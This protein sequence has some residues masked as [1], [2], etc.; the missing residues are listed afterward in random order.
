MTLYF[1]YDKN[2]TSNAIVSLNIGEKI[3][4][5]QTPI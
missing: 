3:E 4:K 1:S 5:K 2:N